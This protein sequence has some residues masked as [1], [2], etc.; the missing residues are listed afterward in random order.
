MSTENPPPNLVYLARK[1]PA[2]GEM[3]QQ[4]QRLLGHAKPE[5]ED[6]ARAT[7]DR[8]DTRLQRVVFL[9]VPGGMVGWI[10][11]TWGSALSKPVAQ[12][13]CLTLVLAGAA[14]YWLDRRR[15]RVRHIRESADR[16]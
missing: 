12:G 5:C 16:E 8:H 13:I 6:C 10:F 14:C 4:I 11:A 3:R 2:L 9:L 7:C 15:A 1:Q